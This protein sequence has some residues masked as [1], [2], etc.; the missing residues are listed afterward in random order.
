MSSSPR[1]I[2]SFRSAALYVEVDVDGFEA[3][4]AALSPFL[5]PVVAGS[6][7]EYAAAC[8]GV[9]GQEYSFS[10]AVAAG[11]LTEDGDPAPGVELFQAE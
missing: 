2:V 11:L 8:G 1:Y 4:K 5:S 9:D 7:D 10:G 6:A 3:A